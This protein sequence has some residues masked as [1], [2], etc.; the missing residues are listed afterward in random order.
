MW[1]FKS[2]YN[3]TILPILAVSVLKV[4]YTCIVDVER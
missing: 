1:N 2:N 4:Q 3:N